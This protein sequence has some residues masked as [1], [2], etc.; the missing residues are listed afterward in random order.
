MA[1]QESKQS[2][3]APGEERVTL[4]PTERAEL[5]ARVETA[6]VL[7]RDAV[8]EAAKVT[9][10]VI[11]AGLIGPADKGGEWETQGDYAKALGV[12]GS[13]LSGLK[14]LGKALSLGLDVEHPA[15]DAVYS[16][17][18]A[19]GKVAAKAVRLSTITAE[20]KR[21]AKTPRAV[22]PASTPTETEEESKPEGVFSA[23]SV[24]REGIPT[25]TREDAR[26]LVASLSTLLEEAKQQ[27][28]AAPAEAQTA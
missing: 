8:V 12:S 23:V 15:F 11:E 9:H 22:T 19:L 1:K 2:L 27:V 5:V 4:T 17:R 18:Q 20:A 26:T 14:A 6:R 10:A 7:G 21:K 25:L 13:N 24:I 16:Q 28:K 3:T